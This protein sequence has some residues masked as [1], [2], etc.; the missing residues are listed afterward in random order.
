MKLAGNKTEN[1][2]TRAQAVRCLDQIHQSTGQKKMISAILPRKRL[3]IRSGQRC[4]YFKQDK[5]K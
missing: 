1:T 3:A 5:Q 2:F 4:G